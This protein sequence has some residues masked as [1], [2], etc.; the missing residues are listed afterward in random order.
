MSDKFVKF[1][2]GVAMLVYG[3]LSARLIAFG[4]IPIITRIY[5]PEEYGAL[6]AFASLMLMLVPIATLRYVTA[7]PLPKNNRIAMSVAALSLC[8]TFIFTLV[9]VVILLP[10]NGYLFKVFNVSR[11]VDYWWLLPLSVLLVS[12][13]EIMSMWAVRKK[14]YK[15]LMKVAVAQSF[16]GEGT[17]VILGLAGY[18]KIGLIIGFVISQS[19]GSGYFIRRFYLEFK[20]YIFSCHPKR[21]GFLMRYYSE[22]PAYRLPSQLLLLFATQSPLLFF[23]YK[24]GVD[25]AGQFGLALMAVML[26]MN[27]IGQ[28]VS[29]AYYAEIASFGKGNVK[30]ISGLTNDLQLKL[31]AAGIPVV[32]VL[33]YL[34]ELLFPMVFGEAWAVAGSYVSIMAL[35]LITQFSSAPLMQVFNVF[36]IQKKYLIINIF[37]VAMLAGLYCLAVMRDIDSLKFLTMY[38]YSMFLFYM[39]IT[40][41]VL[42]FIKARARGVYAA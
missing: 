21:I 37:R 14:D 42:V 34:S 12:I 5:S 36:G 24:Y 27:L 3:S 38:S 16:F 1:Y 39:F 15:G 6:S 20:Q 13:Y 7:V 30:M 22:Y 33:R 8:C 4:S 23:S 18:T 40:I 17:K 11:Y 41:Y 32:L 31:F 25:A 26:P 28:A 10:F 29:K 2:A 9:L 35:Y 19:A